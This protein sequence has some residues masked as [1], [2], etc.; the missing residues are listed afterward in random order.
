MGVC[1]VGCLWMSVL[2]GVFGCLS[3]WVSMDVCHVGCL[4]MSVLMVVFGWMSVSALR[5]ITFCR[6]LPFLNLLGLSHCRVV[7]LS[8]ALSTAALKLGCML[9]GPYKYVFVV[10][11][12]YRII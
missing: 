9:L 4:W 3:C 7:F 2:M 11:V 8:M 12:V 6:S 1:L 5:Y 10:D